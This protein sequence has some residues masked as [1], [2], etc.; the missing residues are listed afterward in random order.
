MTPLSVSPV[1]ISFS[2][3]GDHVRL[4]KTAIPI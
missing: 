2:P 4:V 1:L 3:L